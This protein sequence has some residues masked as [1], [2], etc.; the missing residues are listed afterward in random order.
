MTAA[1]LLAE[2]QSAHAELAD[3][4][5]ELERACGRPVPDEA[6]FTEIRWRL[7]GASLT[8]R[9][10]W[11]KILGFLVPLVTHGEDQAA[12]AD[13]RRLQ[14]EDIALLKA[15]TAHV[16]RW[17]AEAALGDWPAYCEASRIMRGKMRAAMEG[18]KELLYP[19]LE[20]FAAA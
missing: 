13:L 16:G 6:A 12:A 18:E 3:A 19:M 10:L 9:M 8:R 2:L 4:L 11:A 17:S 7:S 14:E 1:A 5:A 15:S 20:K